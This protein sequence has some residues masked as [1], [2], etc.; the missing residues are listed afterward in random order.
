MA[1]TVTATFYVLAKPTSYNRSGKPI[2]GL[3][4]TNL[5]QTK[6]SVPKGSVAVGVR[7]TVPVAVLED[8]TP[9]IDL[10]V[11]GREIVPPAMEAIL[12]GLVERET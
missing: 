5:F 2:T 4:V 12:S 3:K 9:I 8:W 10:T 7:L 1:D 11:T 6:P